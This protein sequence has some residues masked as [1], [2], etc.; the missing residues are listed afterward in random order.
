MFHELSIVNWKR[1]R[2]LVIFQ[3]RSLFDCW[4]YTLNLARLL[5]H[6]PFISVCTVYICK[7]LYTNIS[8]KKH[9]NYLI[10][11]SGTWKLVN[12]KTDLLPS[13][14]KT[15]RWNAL[16][17]MFHW[18]IPFCIFQ[19]WEFNLIYYLPEI[20]TAGRSI[21]SMFVYILWWICHKY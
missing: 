7:R 18:D 13:K 8:F 5:L 3:Q 11:S 16:K 21:K 4:S 10:C 1:K 2:S 17:V 15:K 20:C 9:K 19:F 14:L 6:E 12:T